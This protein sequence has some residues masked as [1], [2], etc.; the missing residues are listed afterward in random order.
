MSKLPRV[1]LA[2]VCLATLARAEELPPRFGAASRDEFRA[3][4][5]HPYVA[6]E[7]RVAKVIAGAKQIKRCAS[8]TEVRRL[9]GAADF[10]ADT[11]LANTTRIDRIG[12]AWSYLLREG[13]ASAGTFDQLITVWMDKTGRVTALHVKG[14][15]GVTPLRA[16]P[17]QT[18]S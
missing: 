18:C 2:G 12:A 11:R 7:A 16:N 6:D 10:G 8:L 3:K 9:L 5:H 14:V 17:Q 13:D 1:L 4:V 15:N